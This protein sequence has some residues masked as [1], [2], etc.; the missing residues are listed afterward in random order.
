MSDPKP[1]A[2]MSSHGF[3][4]SMCALYFTSWK[5]AAVEA[6]CPS[7]GLDGALV[8]MAQEGG[9]RMASLDAAER[10]EAGESGRIPSQATGAGSL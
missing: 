5:L 9:R 3:V 8:A 2:C 1:T 4:Q 10:G 6:P 7:V